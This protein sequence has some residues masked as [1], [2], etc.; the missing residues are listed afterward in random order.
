MPEFRRVDESIA[1]LVKHLQTL[2]EVLHGSFV[3]LLL[4]RE[5]NGQKLLESHSLVT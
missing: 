1:L 2:D 3:L 5:E 4:A